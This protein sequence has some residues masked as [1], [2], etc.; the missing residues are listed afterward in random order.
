MLASVA[1]VLAPYAVNK[2]L[3]AEILLAHVLKVSRVHLHAYPEQIL[4]SMQQSDFENLM[5]RCHLG[6]PVA[7]LTERQAF[8]SMDLR[9]TSATLIPRPET[10][11]L[12]ELALQVSDDVNMKVADLGTGSGA[13]ALALASEK[14]AWDIYAT[15]F[16]VDALSVAKENAERLKIKNIVFRQGDWC[17]ALPKHL[18]DIIVSNPPYVATGDVHLAQ[19]VYDYEPH[20]ALFSR[21]KGLSDIRRIIAR[22]LGYL[23]PGAFLMLEHGF[24]QAAAVSN[25]LADAGYMD[26][27]TISDLAGLDRV[28]MGKNR[29]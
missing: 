11:L 12:V 28:T 17:D 21:E 14:P 18:F 7:Y 3:D 20:A 2:R 25:L 22:A 24:E 1:T 27:K 8:W 29:D 10:E 6:E 4:T 19:S 16:S 9:V 15:D 26:I 23:K 13:V 5:Q